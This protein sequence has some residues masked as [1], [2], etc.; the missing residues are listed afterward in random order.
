MYKQKDSGKGEVMLQSQKEIDIENQ[1]SGLWDLIEG[2]N[3]NSEHTRFTRYFLIDYEN[4]NREG[5]NG[6]TK[7]SEN[8]CVRIYYSNAAETLTFGLHRRINLSKAHFDYIKVQIPIK[9]AADCQILFDIRDLSK[10][11]RTAE[12][13]IVS[14]DSDFDKAVEGF[15]ACSLN[16]RKVQ[17]VCKLLAR[18]DE[19]KEKEKEQSQNQDLKKEETAKN[20][21]APRARRKKQEAVKST[22]AVAKNSKVQTKD[23]KKADKKK[24]TQT[25]RENQIRSFFGQYFKEKVYTDKKEEIIEVLL[26]AKSRMQVN[27]GLTKLYKSETVGPMMKTLRPIIKELPGK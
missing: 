24:G 25:P 8:D 23:V 15:R 20:K 21:T 3:V 17:Q 4:V 7:L 11:N 14:K 26:H 22:T 18:P 6:I 5:L 27:N 2:S 13:F 12:Y 1:E 16:V 19:T 10:K 9:N